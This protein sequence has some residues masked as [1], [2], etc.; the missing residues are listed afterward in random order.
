VTIHLIPD[1]P[2]RFLAL[3]KIKKRPEGTKI[4]WHSW[5]PMQCDITSRYSRKWFSGLFLV[6]ALLSHKVHSF[7][8]TVFWKHQ[9]LLV[10]REVNF[11][12]TWTLH[13]LSC[14]TMY[15]SLFI[16]HNIP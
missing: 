11:A 13:E 3:S 6:V 16:F 14:H 4:C 15:I 1:F 2:L 7:T 10:H 5:H 8:R 9:K 12:F